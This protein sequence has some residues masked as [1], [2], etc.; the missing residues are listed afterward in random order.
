MWPVR[1]VKNMS[2]VTNGTQKILPLAQEFTTILGE[3]S[4]S[5]LKLYTQGGTIDS[6]EPSVP[7]VGGAGAS[8]SGNS[9]DGTFCINTFYSSPYPPPYSAPTPQT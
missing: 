1:S 7:Y 5:T 8:G 6:A 9:S 2:T 4:G 3:V